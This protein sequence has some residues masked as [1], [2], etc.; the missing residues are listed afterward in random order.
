MDVYDTVRADELEGTENIY[1]IRQVKRDTLRIPVVVTKVEDMGDSIMVKGESLDRE[2]I[3]TYFL[4]P[5]E[6]VELWSV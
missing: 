4:Y 1:I 5:Y 6:D 2:G 3:G